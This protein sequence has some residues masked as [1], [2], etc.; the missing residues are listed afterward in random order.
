[1]DELEQL[2]RDKELRQLRFEA[3]HG[4]K[5]SIFL[6]LLFVFLFF[7]GNVSIGKAS[8]RDTT[9]VGDVVQGILL[10]LPLLIRII[11]KRLP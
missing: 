6:W 10:C 1:M 4:R 5:V 7:V 8:F 3:K 11:Q 9:D 2:R